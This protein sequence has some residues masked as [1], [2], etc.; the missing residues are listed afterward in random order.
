MQNYFY[1]LSATGEVTKLRD[2]KLADLQGAV[3]G[4]I[5]YA[6]RFWKNENMLNVIVNEEGI[7]EGLPLNV[8]ASSLAKQSLYGDVVFESRAPI[9][10][11]EEVP[12]FNPEN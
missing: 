11:H 10:S 2:S 1:R 6:P 5:Q 9:V 12:T 7:L 8:F 4:L 3:G